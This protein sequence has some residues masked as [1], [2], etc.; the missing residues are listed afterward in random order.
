MA[1]SAHTPV[2][3][4]ATMKDHGKLRDFVISI[5]VVLDKE[6]LDRRVERGPV[7]TDVDMATDPALLHSN[8]AQASTAV[9]DELTRFRALWGPKVQLRRFKVRTMVLLSFCPGSTR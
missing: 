9:S 1:V 2:W 4:V 5:G 7:S 8:G 6:K 3:D